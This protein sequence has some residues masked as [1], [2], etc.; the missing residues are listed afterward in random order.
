MLEVV[1]DTQEL[2]DS[3]PD[4]LDCGWKLDRRFSY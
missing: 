1:E 2:T 3:C 4:S